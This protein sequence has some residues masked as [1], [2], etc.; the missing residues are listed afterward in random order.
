MTSWL[1]TE[2]ESYS[3]FKGI[4]FDEPSYTLTPTITGDRL[5]NG[6][7][8][9]MSSSLFVRDGNQ[10]PEVV[11]G[12]M[13]GQ[14]AYKFTFND[15]SSPQLLSRLYFGSTVPTDGG[16]FNRDVRRLYW[17]NE[18]SSP[19]TKSILNGIWIKTPASYGLLNGQTGIHRLLGTT[20]GALQN[21]MNIAIGTTS[22]QP[23]IG[24]NH[25][26]EFQGFIPSTALTYNV[27]WDTWYFVAV[28][29]TVSIISE[30]AIGTISTGTLTYTHYIN[31]VEVGTVTSSSW[32][33]ASVCAITWGHNNATASAG[34]WSVSLAGWFVTDWDAVGAEGLEEIYRYG[35]VINAP[36]KYYDGS[37]WQDPINKKVY[38]GSNWID[39]HAAQ[40]TGT[41]WDPI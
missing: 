35:R 16:T 6:N 14:N 34:N 28:K 21:V 37:A 32:R 15:A 13:P 27:E 1:R 33:K 25:Q 7:S 19:A 3:H 18:A 29:R 23:I 24:I 26:P 40:W 17:D 22:G 41:A 12:P 9:T 20:T 39:I 5:W 8:V 10:N 38:D 31:G 11:T 36:V 4:S 2:Q 30:G